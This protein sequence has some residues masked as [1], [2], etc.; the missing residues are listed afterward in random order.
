MVFVHIDKKNCINGTC[1]L[2]KELDTSLGN[3]NTKTFLL[4][5]MEGCGPC[6]ATRPEWTKIKNI[7]QPYF[8]KRKD[9]VIAAIDH[10]LA[11]KLENLKT[12]PTGFP[13]M[14]FITDGGNTSENYEDS[15]II[16]KGS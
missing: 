9:I 14:R 10:Q 1:N 15:N 6:N 3:K 2:I 7:L 13:T 5:F 11:E 16:K 4:I 8:L 12:K